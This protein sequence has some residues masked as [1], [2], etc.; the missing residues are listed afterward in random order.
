VN[1]DAVLSRKPRLILSPQANHIDV[2]ALLRERSRELHQRW[3]RL[4]ELVGQQAN[5]H[6]WSVRLA[7]WV[8]TAGLNT[9]SGYPTKLLRPIQL[10]PYG[11]GFVL[12]RKM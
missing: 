9:F 6:G 7:D 5:V 3:G 8:D 12:G 1:I 4:V 10:K 2:I 11:G